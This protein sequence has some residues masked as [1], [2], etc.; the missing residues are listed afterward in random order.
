MDS[1][2]VCIVQPLRRSLNGIN[3]TD[4][5]SNRHIR[6]RKFFRKS[7]FSS[8]P[9]D[10]SII[11]LLLY[12]VDTMFTDWFVGIIVDLASFDNRDDFIQQCREDTYQS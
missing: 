9:V 12:Q 8:E 7:I 10:F 11:A 5:I 3:I 2:F 4:E 1:S 6:R